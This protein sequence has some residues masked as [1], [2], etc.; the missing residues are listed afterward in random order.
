MIRDLAGT[1]YPAVLALNSAFEFF[2]SPMDET[3]LVQ[4]HQRASY[5]RVVRQHSAAVAFVLAFRERAVY[6]SPNYVWFDQ[7]YS[8]F[9]YVDRI[10]V[11]ADHQGKHLGRALYTDLFRF[12]SAARIPRVTCEFDLEP[13]NEVSRRFHAQFG[14]REVGTQRV[15]YGRKQVS[16]QE[17]SLAQ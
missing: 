16:L 13:P 6:D 1:D 3:R 5:A 15:A 10:V 4:L 14:F 9:L 7:R 12:A 11:S 17:A 8:S 2:L